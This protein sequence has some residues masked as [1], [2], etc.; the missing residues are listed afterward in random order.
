MRAMS[1]KSLR[2]YTDESSR[3]VLV[4]RYVTFLARAIMAPLSLGSGNICLLITNSI[5]EIIPFIETNSYYE[6]TKK[7]P[8]IY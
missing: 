5:E 4:C 3:M 7:L 2:R 6:I 8:A 1:L